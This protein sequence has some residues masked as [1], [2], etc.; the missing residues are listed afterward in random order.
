MVEREDRKFINLSKNTLL[1]TSVLKPARIDFLPENAM[2][3]DY[4]P[5]A[6]ASR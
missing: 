5:G 2:V 4:I 6:R 3:L 1:D